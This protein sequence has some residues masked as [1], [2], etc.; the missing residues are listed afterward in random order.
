MKL[1]LI[2]PVVSCMLFI[3]L[4]IVSQG[5]KTDE[6]TADE[7]FLSKISGEWTASKIAVDDVVLEGAFD[8]F[9]L[10]LTAE[11]KYV[12]TNGNAPI[13]PESG[14]FALKQVSSIVGFNVLR[15]DGVEISIKEFSEKRLVLM[16]HY[17]SS[18][19]RSSSVTGD[20]IFELVR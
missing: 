14:S 20:Y 9:K 8:G 7:V 13:W 5:C 4:I 1:N 6:P 10:S 18:S 3:S 15:D 2:I 16:F 11:K 19:G 12:T 17:V